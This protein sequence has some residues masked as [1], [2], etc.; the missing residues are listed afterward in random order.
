MQRRLTRRAIAVVVVGALALLG[1]AC[2]DDEEPTT[3]G[4]APSTSSSESSATIPDGPTITIGAQDFPESKILSEI[5][6]QA[7]ENAGYDVKQ[8]DLG[9]F[10]DIVYTSF[11]S[12]DINFTAEYAAS[13]LEFLNGF[14]GEA[15]PDIDE[16]AAKLAP[17]L[18]KK[19]LQALEAAPAVDSNALVMTAERAEELHATKISDLTEDLKLGATPDCE[20]NASCIPGLKTKYGL[21]FSENFTPLD[22]GGPLTVKALDEGAIDVGILFTTSGVIAQKGW[23]ILEDDKGF[24]NADNIIPVTSDAVVEAYGQ[25]FID[26]INEISAAITTEKLSELNKRVDSDKEDPDKVATDF[27][28]EADLL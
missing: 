7:L 13:A 24:V 28:T 17:Q 27:L 23:V 4:A 6:G 26:L 16:T 5:Y 10:R 21:D 12:G 19:G 14:A 3:S 9:G 2:G 11:K 8:Q 25:D 20:E 15:T 22:G 18:E 1:A